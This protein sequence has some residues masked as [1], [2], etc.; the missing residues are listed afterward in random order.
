MT[1]SKAQDTEEALSS[2]TLALGVYS[3]GF[4]STKASRG[5]MDGVGRLRTH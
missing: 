4:N 5:D 1:D 2:T 3:A